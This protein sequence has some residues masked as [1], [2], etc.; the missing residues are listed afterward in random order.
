VKLLLIG[1]EH[2]RPKL[3]R[4]Y[5]VLREAHDIETAYF[6]D[7]RSGITRTLGSEYT[8]DAWFAPNPSGG[9]RPLLS[10]WR[11]F[12][13]C[14]R[15]QRPDVLEVYS[16]IHA[17]VLFPMVLYARLSGVPVVVVCRGELYP[18]EFSRNSRLWQ[19]LYIRI[20][21][22]AQ[23]IVYKEPYMPRL[24]ERYCPRVPR[25]AWTNAV[26]VR[27]DEP[28]YERERNVIL[29][30]NFFK[31]WRNLEVIVDAAAEVTRRFPD[32]RFELVGSTVNLAETSGFYS[33]L[34]DYERRISTRIGALGLEEVVT[35]RPFT[36]DTE[37]FISE[38]KVFLLPA[39]VVYC[40]YTLLE[41]MERG[42]PPIV[43]ADRDEHAT[44]IVEHEV[45]GLVERIDAG[46][47][48]G[49]IIRLLEDEDLR[50]RLGR[51]A[52]QAIRDRFNLD[53]NLQELA[54]WY[55]T[56]SGSA[57]GRLP[58]GEDPRPLAV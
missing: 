15:R 32:A 9:I 57:A 5:R 56:L 47:L 40:N 23:L 20:L 50:Q 29:F 22:L 46:V 24:L 38:A 4:H 13:R 53:D 3:A 1:E 17:A 6:V 8:I 14:F 11:Q 31:E 25:F 21:R 18:P 45:S 10:Y 39:D 19:F 2:I 12:V 42:V 16:S 30:L 7:D 48:A 33:G 49:A 55:R 52:R 54:S 34:F 35:I 58:E 36:P 43:S 27:P 37:S 28:A 26:P 41:A 51:N 44:R